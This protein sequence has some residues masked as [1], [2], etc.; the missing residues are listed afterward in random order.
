MN[1]K[2]IKPMFL[3]YKKEKEKMKKQIAAVMLAATLL[4]CN[5]YA[6]ED[7]NNSYQIG[8]LSYELSSDWIETESSF[9]SQ[10]SL[11]LEYK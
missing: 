3:D 7:V 6:S 1:A 2:K 4:P 11:V 8:L 5:V 9:E 10:E